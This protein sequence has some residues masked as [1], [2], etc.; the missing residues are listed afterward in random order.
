MYETHFGLGERPFQL[1]PDPRF[2]FETATHGKAMAYLG[3]GL[4]QGEG[5]IVITGDVG[6]GKTTLVGHLVETLDTRRLRVIHI[7]STAIQPDDL[8]RSVA[9]QLGVDSAGLSKATLL[10]AIER[11][12]NGVARDGR[13]VL[14]IVDEAQALPIASLEELRMLSNFQAG[15]HALLQ[16][17][18]VG[19]PEFRDRLLGSGAIEQLR[20][21][22]I[23]IHHLDPMEPEEVP[24]YIAHRLAVAGWTGRPDFAADAF[25]ALYEASGGVPRRLNVLAGRVLLQAAIEGIEMVGHETVESVAADM[26]ADLAVGPAA[27]PV[28]TPEPAPRPA[29]IMAPV[30]GAASPLQA[31]PSPASPLSFGA[32]TLGGTTIGPD[33]LNG[34]MAEIGATVGTLRP[35][36]FG[37]APADRPVRPETIVADP[38]TRTRV[39]PESVAMSS[40]THRVV[41]PPP[42]PEPVS[43][44]PMPEPVAA[45]PEA[46]PARPD[47]A[48]IESAKPEPAQI[49][50]A[51]TEA[52]EALEGRIAQLEARLEQQEAALRRVLTLLVDWT[53]MDGRGDSRSEGKG[54][55]RRDAP[56]TIRPAG[57]WGHAA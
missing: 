26:A 53:E 1:T 6:A 27:E 12:L 51:A 36:M 22:I 38:I 56:A 44:R 8:L 28:F 16:I 43:L 48:P 31:V 17:L 55:P 21:R 46:G 35:G 42:A 24:D 41:A 54:E 25:D 57:A 50:P 20:Q 3:Y 5:F 10:T 40:A 23:A 15:G 18:L 19:Q 2:W 29:P 49:D 45:A 9:E 32:G 7:V 52:V 47:A 11:A 30:M 13:R 4:A 37:G 39:V 14:L 34:M 33:M